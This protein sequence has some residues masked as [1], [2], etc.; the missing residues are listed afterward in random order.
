MK[1]TCI[2]YIF[3]LDSNPSWGRR[4]GQGF[5]WVKCMSGTSG[6]LDSDNCNVS[7][8][9][10]HAGWASAKAVFSYVRKD[11]CVCSRAAYGKR[12][13]VYRA[14]D[15]GLVREH[16][17]RETK[18]PVTLLSIGERYSMI[19]SGWGNKYTNMPLGVLQYWFVWRIGKVGEV[20]LLG[21]EVPTESNKKV[22]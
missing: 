4:W 15:R 5:G 17:G 11:G 2:C 7:D 12:K 18:K 19:D 9:E 10:G 22:K 8:R 21:I 6:F 1:W 20:E 13:G 3:L 16:V 14:L